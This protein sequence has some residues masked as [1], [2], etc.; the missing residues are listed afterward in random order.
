MF[1]ILCAIA[2]FTLPDMF[3]FQHV[4][5]T[6]G[7]HVP[8]QGN[9]VKYQDYPWLTLGYMT[10]QVPVLIPLL[11]LCV[12]LIIYCGSAQRTLLCVQ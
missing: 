3:C 7:H 10:Q 1:I 5:H 8:K 4:Q 9:K 2:L 6:V 11:S 12:I